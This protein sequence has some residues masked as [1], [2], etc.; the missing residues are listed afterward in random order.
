MSSFEDTLGNFVSKTV[1]SVEGFVNKTAENV[2]DFLKGQ[3]I[4]QSSKGVNATMGSNA[5]KTSSSS[6]STTTTTAPSKQL[7]PIFSVAYGVNSAGKTVLYPIGEL[8]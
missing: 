6:S 4:D 5:S 8:L 7:I 3:P 1:S 2:S